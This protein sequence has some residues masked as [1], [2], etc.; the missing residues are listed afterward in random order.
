MDTAEKALLNNYID[1][2]LAENK[3]TVSDVKD[4][5]GLL[6]DSIESQ[7]GGNMYKPQMALL[8]SGITDSVRKVYPINTDLDNIDVS[9]FINNK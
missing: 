8:L 2:F 9:K 4:I 6:L 7:K 1:L 5:I 3:C